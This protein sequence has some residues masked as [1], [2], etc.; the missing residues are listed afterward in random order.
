MSVGQTVPLAPTAAGARPNVQ[1]PA[2]DPK[3]GAGL[4]LVLALLA[5][6]APFAT[7]LYLPAFPR[8]TDDLVPPPL[9]CS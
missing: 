2:P 7:D 9:Q 1:T 8:M 6:L 3:I 5:A 4:L